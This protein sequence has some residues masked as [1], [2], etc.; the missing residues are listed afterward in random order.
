M[1]PNRDDKAIRGPAAARFG[2]NAE[3]EKL[4]KEGGDLSVRYGATTVLGVE[5]RLEVNKSE[6]T[7]VP[8]AGEWLS[9]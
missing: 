9:G 7:G 1:S 3:A 6:Y 8:P 4:V 5:Y 2:F